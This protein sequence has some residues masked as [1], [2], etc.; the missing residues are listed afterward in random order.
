MAE[1]DDILARRRSELASRRGALSA[2]KQQELERL[3]NRSVAEES[4]ARMIP[5]RPA[6][7]PAP[8][9]FAQERLWFLYQLEP[10]S[11]AYNVCFP[12]RITGRLNL[13]A[14]NQSINEA[15]R[16]HESLRTTFGAVDG[17]PVQNINPARNLDLPIVD[18]SS[19]P[20]SQRKEVVGRLVDEGS[21]RRFNLTEGPL[22]QPALFRV[23]KDEHVLLVL[24]HHIIF[25]EWSRP[26]L[27]RDVGKIY[28][29]FDQ[30]QPSSLPELPIQYSD[31]AHWHRQSLRDEVLEQEL[32]Y[33]RTQLDDS[34]L[35]MNLPTDRP[36]PPVMTYQGDAL[37]IVVP[38]ELTGKLRNLTR[39]AGTSLFMT[40]L[41]SFQMLLSRYTGQDDI[42]VA[43]PVA[44][45]RSVDT[46]DL[47]GF[48]VNTLLIRTRL[49]GNP[50]LREVIDRVRN[51][52]LEAQTHQDLPFE[53][54]VEELHPE[55]SLSHGPLFEVMFVFTNKPRT[56]MEVQDISISLLET[57][58]GTEKF[59]L[60][61]EISEG[62]HE[63]NCSLSY[64]TDL[65]DR[66]T[67]ERLGR[68]WQR[69]LEAMV[70]EPDRLLSNVELLDEDEQ[71][72]IITEWN[73]TAVSWAEA[74]FLS[75]FQNQVDLTPDVPA[76]QLADQHLSYRELDARAN[77]LAHHL[78]HLGVSADTRVGICLEPSLEMMTGVLGVL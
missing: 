7:E 75:L 36:R 28:E 48:F 17:R 60:T 70:T 15:V 53:K 18:L 39:S 1:I 73:D 63:L 41:A 9:S 38:E 23:A 47:I 46:E 56:L 72:E 11:S 26:L 45:R 32:S 22:F 74:S 30:G 42:V 5:A 71:A 8:L 78:F 24:L 66:S 44:G 65:F 12:L 31:F 27:V 64:R 55:R 61:F 76:V 54:L 4:P 40:L 51:V 21:R 57:I 62:F 19:L 29:A 58:S 25:D 59:G 68:H 69:L 6:D 35:M 3:L 49:A 16:D 77:Q 10:E 33:W 50:R 67:I 43:T 34:P 20:D 2:L 14:L 13:A 37:P 52:V